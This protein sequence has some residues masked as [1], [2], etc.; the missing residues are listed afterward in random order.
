VIEILFAILA[1]HV[2]A[3]AWPFA[4]KFVTVLGMTVLLALVTYF[5]AQ[6]LGVFGDFVFPAFFLLVHAIVDYLWDLIVIS[7]KYHEL[8]AGKE[9]P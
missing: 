1:L 5:G 2:L 4:G 8:I 7:R 3:G 6:N 9:T